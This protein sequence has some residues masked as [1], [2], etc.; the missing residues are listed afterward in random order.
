[1][2][3]LVDR[4]NAEESQKQAEDDV[5]KAASTASVLGNPVPQTQLVPGHLVSRI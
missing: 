4:V 3:V 5:K 1:M 2:K